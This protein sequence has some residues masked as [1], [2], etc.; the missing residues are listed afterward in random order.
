MG[1]ESRICEP[2]ESSTMY[3]AD[4]LKQHR[5]QDHDQKPIQVAT[6]NE[7][8]YQV[9]VQDRRDQMTDVKM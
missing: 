1:T 6:K 4:I 7:Y 2:K 5:N 8:K 3:S 9:G